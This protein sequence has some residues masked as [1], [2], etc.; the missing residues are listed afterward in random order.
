MVNDKARRS[1]IQFEDVS[2][3]YP[4]AE[5]DSIHHISLDVKEGEFLVLTGG[6][7]CGKT[8]LTRLVNGLGEQFYE[9]TLKGRITLLGRNISE[10]PLYEIGKRASFLPVLQRMR[11][12]LGVKIMAFRMK[13]WI[14]G[15]QVQSSVLTEICCEGKKFIRCPAGK[16]RK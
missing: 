12:R 14:G 13:N 8:T 2:F 7:G 4:G 11:F 3:E 10:Y 9:G 5:T 15:F 1:V 16:N 6:S